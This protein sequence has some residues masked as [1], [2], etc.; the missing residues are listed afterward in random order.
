[1]VSVEIVA[2]AEPIAA[3]GAVIARPLLLPEPAPDGSLT[4]LREA[5]DL[6]MD[7]DFQAAR[8]AYYDWV[9]DFFAPLQGHDPARPID[10]TSLALASEK[11]AGLLDRERSAVR[12]H[13]RTRRWRRA[14][15]ALT[16]IGLAAGGAGALS[17]GA[18]TEVVQ[19]SA[20]ILGWVT[21]KLPLPP[22]D[23]PP[24]T[25]TSMFATSQQHLDWLER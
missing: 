4:P 2:G 9:R 17:A 5:V 15:A 19:A 11:L 22:P 21:G 25:G 24:L 7:D 23:R 10:A 8:R 3:V 1:M 18:P 20:G 6:A 13:R 12:Q 16:I 14:T